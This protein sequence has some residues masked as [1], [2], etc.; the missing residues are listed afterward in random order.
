MHAL[1]ALLVTAAM[2]STDCHARLPVALL[3]HD[4]L[5][6]SLALDCAGAG[7]G[8]GPCGRQVGGSRPAAGQPQRR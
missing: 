3:T 2:Q 6:S 1:T 8:G 5:Q 4:E 7:G